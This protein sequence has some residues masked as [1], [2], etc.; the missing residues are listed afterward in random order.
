MYSYT[1][2]GKVYSH[3]NVNQLQKLLE[4]A[5]YTG[6][7]MLEFKAALTQADLEQV[8]DLLEPAE[9]ELLETDIVT[10]EET[11][12][13]IKNNKLILEDDITDHTLN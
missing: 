13:D 5:G 3:K 10:E 4:K 7:V 9:T 11:M 12:D 6:N 2:K 1:Y 8:A